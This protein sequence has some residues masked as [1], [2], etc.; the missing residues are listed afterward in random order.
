MASLQMILASTHA[1]ASRP[2]LSGSPFFEALP[3]GV[4]AG[5]APL[6]RA[7]DVGQG[8]GIPEQEAGEQLAGEVLGVCPVGGLRRRQGLGGIQLHTEG[9][10]TW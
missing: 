5:E 6:D 4:V 8:D 7:V 3:A 2:A 10:F 1:G 9:E